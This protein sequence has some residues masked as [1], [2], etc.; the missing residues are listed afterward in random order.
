M[1]SEITSVPP[2][3]IPSDIW[4]NKELLSLG[5]PWLTPGCIRRLEELLRP[6]HVVLEMGSGGS[7]VFFSKRAQRVI[8]IEPN[9][10]WFKRVSSE[11]AI[12]GKSNVEYHF[13]EDKLRIMEFIS[14]LPDKSFDIMLADFPGGLDKGG[15]LRTALPKLK[16]DGYLII[17]NYFMPDYV[18]LE[19][20]YLPGWRCEDYN[21]PHWWGSGT[22]ICWRE[23]I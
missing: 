12:N 6:N 23:P 7:T 9:G 21:N 5:C 10:D 15:Y 14:L 16:T 8:S 20:L 1:M 22:R 17:D 2:V 13:I 11:L 18:K 3:E 19:E 4:C